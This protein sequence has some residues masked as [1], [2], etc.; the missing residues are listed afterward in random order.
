LAAVLGAETTSS[1]ESS[2]KHTSI[3]LGDLVLAEASGIPLIEF[4]KDAERA[5]NAR[6]RATR[7]S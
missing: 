3:K 5:R 2:E 7:R 6:A 1:E 4:A